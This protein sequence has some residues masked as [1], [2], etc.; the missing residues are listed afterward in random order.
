VE[1]GLI[2]TGGADRSTTRRNQN[3]YFWYWVEGM[4]QNLPAHQCGNQIQDGGAVPFT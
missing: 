1:V 4:K 3:Y 2:F